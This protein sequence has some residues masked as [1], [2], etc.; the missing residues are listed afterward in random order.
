MSA[1]A[2]LDP[3][4]E[5]KRKIAEADARE[6]A[7]AAEAEQTQVTIEDIAAAAFVALETLVNI[8]GDKGQQVIDEFER[9]VKQYTVE[10]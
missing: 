3:I 2:P 10:Q 1:E 9:R 7:Q 8:L 5:L 6:A 4:E